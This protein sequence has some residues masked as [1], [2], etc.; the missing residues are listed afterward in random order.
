MVGWNGFYCFEKLQTHYREE[1]S[2]SRAASIEDDDDGHLIY[3]S[4]DVLQERC[5]ENIQKKIT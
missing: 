4:G 2:N 1:E 5:T 3:K